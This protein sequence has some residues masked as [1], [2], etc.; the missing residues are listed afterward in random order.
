MALGALGVPTPQKRPLTLHKQGA[1]C[2]LSDGL[3]Q[4]SGIGGGA[5]AGVFCAI[6]VISVSVVRIIVAI[7][8]AFSSAER[9]TF[10]GSMMP[11]STMSAYS[12]RSEEHTS[13]L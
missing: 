12:P 2:A 11:R 10:K 13:E 3:D 9:V 7:E 5:G 1:T 8:A 4:Y 6:S